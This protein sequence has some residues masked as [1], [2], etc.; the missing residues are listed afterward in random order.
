MFKIPVKMLNMKAFPDDHGWRFGSAISAFY[1]TIDDT[2]AIYETYF[3]ETDFSSNENDSSSDEND[4]SSDKND[5]S[6]DE[7]DSSSDEN[8]SS[9]DDETVEDNSTQD[10]KC[11]KRCCS[12]V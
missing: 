11:I 4:S 6:S 10:G 8:D 12:I 7:N 5:S 9:T 3:I 1:I 2:N